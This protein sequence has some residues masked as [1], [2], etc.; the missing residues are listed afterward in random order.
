MKTSMM[1]H[2]CRNKKSLNNG[3]EAAYVFER[4]LLA[5]YGAVL[6]GLLSG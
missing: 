6:V 4:E 5:R 2:E 1:N 3:H